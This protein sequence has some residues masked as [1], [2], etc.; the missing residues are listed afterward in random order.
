[1]CNGSEGCLSIALLLTMILIV[2]CGGTAI[3]PRLHEA[4]ELEDEAEAIEITA[5]HRTFVQI[6]VGPT[7]RVVVEV[8]AAVFAGSSAMQELIAKSPAASTLCDGMKLFGT[9]ETIWQCEPNKAV[10][11]EKELNII[12][13]LSL[14]RSEE[15]IHAATRMEHRWVTPDRLSFAMYAEFLSRQWNLKKKVL[16]CKFCKNKHEQRL[17]LSTA[18]TWKLPTSMER[19]GIT[20]VMHVTVILWR[21]LCLCEL[22]SHAP[23]VEDV[24]RS[25]EYLKNQIVMLEGY[26]QLAIWG[27]HGGR[28]TLVCSMSWL[29]WNR[30]LLIERIGTFLP[31]LTFES[32]M[33]MEAKKMHSSSKVKSNFGT[34]NL[35]DKCC[36]FN[37][38]TN[39]CDFSRGTRFKSLN[40]TMMARLRDVDAALTSMSV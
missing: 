26:Q 23:K 37:V 9:N 20:A 18:P 8:V 33:D 21:P 30:T 14:L 17:S 27:Q 24:N 22:S 32:D 39:Q 1:M 38:T 12:G 15:S 10:I 3:D 19:A 16:V 35:P 5:K 34:A 31:Q 7:A 2:V 40:A 13:G 4:E 28:P 25:R 11:D 6:T 29:V 36:G